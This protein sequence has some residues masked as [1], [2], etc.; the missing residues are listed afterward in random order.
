MTFDSFISALES[1]RTIYS[2]SLK[3]G[4]SSD[5][6]SDVRVRILEELSKL[7]AFALKLANDNS[8]PSYLEDLDACKDAIIAWDPQGPWLRETP[9]V[10]KALDLIISDSI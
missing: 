4:F 3:G 7:K 10:V 1:I 8:Q 9:T 6:E 2:V 5:E